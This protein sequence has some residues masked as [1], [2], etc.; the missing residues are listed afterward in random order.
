MRLQELEIPKNINEIMKDYS[1]DCT[2]VMYC[3]RREGGGGG[4]GGG[5]GQVSWENK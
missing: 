5:G 3:G 4:G 2:V 1:K